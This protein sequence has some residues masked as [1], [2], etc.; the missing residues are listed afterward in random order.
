MK[1]SEDNSNDIIGL[2]YQRDMGSL[3]Y[4]ILCTRLD[5]V[6][7]ISVLNKHMTN[8]SIEHQIILK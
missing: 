8:S 7:F 4:V 5:L 2:F 6:Y 1:K 3:M